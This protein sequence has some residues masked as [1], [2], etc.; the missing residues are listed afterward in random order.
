MTWWYTYTVIPKISE[1][2]SLN[3][4]SGNDPTVFQQSTDDIKLMVV[5]PMLK[6]YLLY[7]FE[8]GCFF[9]GLVWFCIAGINMS[10]GNESIRPVPLISNEYGLLALSSLLIITVAISVP[11]SAGA[12]MT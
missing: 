3:H 11:C 9:Y 6:G 4:V 2:S 1:P 10:Q 12:N 5:L 7:I 8:K